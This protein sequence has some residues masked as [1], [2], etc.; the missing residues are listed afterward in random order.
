MSLQFVKASKIQKT[1]LFSISAM[2]QRL[3]LD[4]ANPPQAATP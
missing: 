1:F 4:Q 2:G 3:V